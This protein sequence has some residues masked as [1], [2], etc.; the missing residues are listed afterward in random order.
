MAVKP[1]WDYTSI[2]QDNTYQ[3][4]EILLQMETV[5]NFVTPESS[6]KFK[7]SKKHEYIS[8]KTS[9]IYLVHKKT[10]DVDMF[11]MT[12]IPAISYLES[13]KFDP[14]K[15]MSYLK[16]DKKFNGSII[17]H[18]MNGEFVNGWN[19]TD[20]EVTATIDIKTKTNDFDLVELRSTT[21]TTIY[22]EVYYEFCWQPG[23]YYSGE[24]MWG[25]INCSYSDYSYYY[26]E[27]CNTSGGDGN[28]NGGGGGGGGNSGQSLPTQVILS[29]KPTITIMD[30]Y[31]LI[32]T[33][34]P[35]NYS[36]KAV[37]FKINNQ[38]ELQKNSS[39]TCNEKAKKA[40][41][42]AI[43]AIV[44]GYESNIYNVNVQFPE[45]GQIR[46]QSVIM[47]AMNAAWSSTRAA[48]TQNS[49]REEG[50]SIYVNNINGNTLTYEV[51]T[52]CTGSPVSCGTTATIAISRNETT[53]SSPLN[54]G[55]YCV[56]QFHTHTPF[57]YCSKTLSRNV[58]PSGSD[59]DSFCPQ[60]IFDY[61]AGPLVGGHN[62]NDG[63]QIY[64][65]GSRRTQ[66]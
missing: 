50:F 25:N 11:L 56:A 65:L 38:Y 20:G 66:Y 61:S 21:C 59:S 3:A 17:F 7:N 9:L 45:I 52:T 63:A 28:Y 30:S 48:T 51:G 41:N 44:D 13:T 43:K 32:V 5:F 49:R 24:I 35:S 57:T 36:P 37:I 8:S 47:S 31:S 42:W 6:E 34:T 27:Q 12:I 55:K 22:W 60:L 33:I 64:T 58:G 40:G 1:S 29:G 62:I 26:Y 54:G 19:Y 53:S 16:R 15:K 39:T 10:G 4:V 18:N 23:Y 2:E 14:F 46:A